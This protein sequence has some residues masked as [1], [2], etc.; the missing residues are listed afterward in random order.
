MSWACRFVLVA[1]IPRKPWA[2]LF[3]SWASLFSDV[4][5]RFAYCHLVG[6]LNIIYN[7]CLKTFWLC[8]NF[9]SC[10]ELSG[11]LNCWWHI[12]SKFEPSITILE[13]ALLVERGVA[14]SERRQL[15][16]FIF[17][18]TLRSSSSWWVDS[19]MATSAKVE[20]RTNWVAEM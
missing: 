20:V 2:S 5:F 4:L 3:S 18:I 8:L 12:N 17:S 6:W 9:F 10:E 19:F 11:S 16:C 14:S 15:F 1:K 13:T 7:K